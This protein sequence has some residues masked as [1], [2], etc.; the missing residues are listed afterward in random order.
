MEGKTPA[1]DDYIHREFNDGSYD[2]KTVA[3][4]V[5]DRENM[6]DEEFFDAI[7]SSVSNNP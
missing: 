5:T 1:S 6:T 2:V 7:D 4:S 3:T